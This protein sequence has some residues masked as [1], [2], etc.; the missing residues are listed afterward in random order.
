MRHLQRTLVACLLTVAPSALAADAPPKPVQDLDRLVGHWKGTAMLAMDGKQSPLT[1]DIDCSKGA[2]GFGVRCTTAFGGMPG[3]GAY[4]EA[5]LFGYEPN[6]GKYHWFAVT[7][8]G[9]THDHM[10]VTFGDTSRWVYEG[11]QDGKPMREAIDLTFKDGKSFD[12]K[13]ETLLGGASVATLTIAV[14]K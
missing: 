3:V 9:E 7:N 8:G 13:V 2:G 12:C 5:D 14:K 4:A 1:V 6:S 10:A 11:M